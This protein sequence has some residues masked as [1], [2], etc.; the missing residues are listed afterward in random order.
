MILGDL[1]LKSFLISLSHDCSAAFLSQDGFVHSALKQEKTR[2]MG[3]L[4]S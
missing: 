4:K 1:L 3:P 2:F